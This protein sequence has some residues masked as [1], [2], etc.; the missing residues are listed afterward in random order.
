MNLP[1]FTAE[2]SLGKSKR[3][4]HGKYV[5]G[6]SSQSQRGFPASVLPSQIEVLGDADESDMVGDEM[7]DEVMEFSEGEMEFEVSEDMDYL[8]EA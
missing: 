5:Y 2:S 7:D 3:A 8:E 6:D 1:K 4:Y